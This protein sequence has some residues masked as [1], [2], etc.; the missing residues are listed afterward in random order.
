MIVG[1]DAGG[2][3][4]EVEALRTRLGMGLVGGEQR[5]RRHGGG[6]RRRGERAL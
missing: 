4:L 3:F 6:D 1:I 2:H 5:Q